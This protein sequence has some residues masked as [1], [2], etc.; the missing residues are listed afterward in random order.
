MNYAL[1]PKTVCIDGL[2]WYLHVIVRMSATTINFSFHDFRTTM[3]CNDSKLRR[4]HRCRL[5]IVFGSPHSAGRSAQS[6]PLQRHQWNIPVMPLLHFWRLTIQ[7]LKRYG[8]MLIIFAL[9]ATLYGDWPTVQS[10][11]MTLASHRFLRIGDWTISDYKL[12][13][14]LSATWTLSLLGDMPPLRYKSGDL[15]ILWYTPLSASVLVLCP[16][17]FLATTWHS[18]FRP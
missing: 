12:S 14:T 17:L 4:S 8:D 11:R 2:L 5:E 10:A 9:D 15:L 18:M 3:V 7:R 16:S 6:V 13:G 1:L